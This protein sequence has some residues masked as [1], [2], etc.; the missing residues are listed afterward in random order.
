VPDIRLQSVKSQDHATLPRQRGAQAI[1]VAKRGRDELIVAVE[2]MGDRAFRDRHAPLAQAAVDLG[3]AAVLAV[4][5]G[6][7]QRDHLKAE[8]VLRQ[9]DG[10]LGFRPV[11]LVITR[12]ARVLAAADLQAQADQAR[13][14]GHRVPVVVAV[15]Q[16]TTAGQAVLAECLE[17]LLALRR[18]ARRCPGHHQSPSG[19]PLGRST[20]SQL[21]RSSFL[22]VGRIG[23]GEP[24]LGPLLAD[25]QPEQGLPD[26]LG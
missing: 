22:R 25:L 14:R 3:H 11:G 20:A 13:E 15:A 7:D 6:T 21:C 8:L 9:H 26:G 19:H 24:A 2:Q 12:A 18:R 5:Q 16:P 10:T 17:H 4:A 23:A 1:I